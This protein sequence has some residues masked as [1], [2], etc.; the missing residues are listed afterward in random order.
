MGDHSLKKLHATPPL[1]ATDCC[2]F[3]DVDGTLIDFA[4]NPASVHVDSELKTLLST[5]ATGLGGALA[6]VSGRSI[7]ALDRLFD[8]LRP[9]AAGLHGIERR[10]ASGAL[11]G[12]SR[13]DPRLDAARG[14]LRAFTAANP[15]TLLEDKGRALAL[16]FNAAPRLETEARAAVRAIAVQLGERYHVLDGFMVVELKPRDLT[17]ATAIEAFLQEAPFLHRKPVFIGDD[18]TDRDGFAA[19]EA[20]G[21]MS[22]AVGNRVR[23]QHHCENPRVV[24][25]WLEAFAA[26]LTRRADVSPAKYPGSR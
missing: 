15:D 20:R 19:V 7:A 5:L 4:S 25:A 8:P 17:K 2:L 12:D 16:H 10:S 14:V 6:L 18:V 21:G 9:A 23:A 22:I 26:T 11:H 24:R 3:L 1:P 13:P